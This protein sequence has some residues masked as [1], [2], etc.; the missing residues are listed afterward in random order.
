MFRSIPRSVRA[1]M[2]FEAII[3]RD[4]DDSPLEESI[5]VCEFAGFLDADRRIPGCMLHPCAPGN[6]GVDLRGMCHYGSMA[7]KTFFCPAWENMDALHREILVRSID[8][9]HL[10]GLVITDTNFVRS[11]FGI[12]EESLGRLTDA[13]RLLTGETGLIFKEMISWKDTWPFKA[14]SSL[15]GSSYYVKTESVQLEPGSADHLDEILE[16]FKFTFGT[17]E[18]NARVREYIRNAVQRLVAA[19]GR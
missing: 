16:S 14:G 17:T 19:Y 2:D 3:R 10:Y 7:C 6:N 4:E 11:L 18:R 9:W 12:L 8:D 1:L 5:H 15:R 13:D